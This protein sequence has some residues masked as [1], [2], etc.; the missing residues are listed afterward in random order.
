MQRSTRRLSGERIVSLPDPGPYIPVEGAMTVYVR[1]PGNAD[2]IR[3]VV[4]RVGTEPPVEL[5]PEVAP[6]P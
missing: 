3:G 1:F 6:G 2:D 5:T 4:M